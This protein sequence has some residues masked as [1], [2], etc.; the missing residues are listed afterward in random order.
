[1][2]T[3]KEKL[4]KR[5][6]RIPNKFYY[7][8]YHFIMTDIVGKKYKP[9]YK[10]IDDI[11]DCKGPC[12]LIWNHLSRVDH[13]Y[14]MSL[15]YP[16]PINIVAAY[17]E[18]YRSHL[19][20]VFK[21]MNILPKK[22]FAQDI[23][24]IRAM[25]SI[26][27]KG[28]VVCFAPEGMSSIYGTN[29]P[30]VPGTGRFIKHYGIPVYYMELRGQYLTSTKVCLDERPGRTEATL[31]LLF[32]PE[33]LEKMSA[34]EIEAKI[35]ETF[36]SDDYEW[37]KANHIKW[38]N[39]GNIC[40]RLDDICYKCPRCASEMEM[41]ASGDHIECKKCGNG[42]KMN[43][44]YEFLPYNTDCVIP[45]SPSKWV[46]WERGEMIK[47]IR[48][49]ANYSLCEKVKLGYLPQD[50]FVKDHKTSEI[51]GEGVFS[52]DHTGVH[53]K[54][55]KLGEAWGF[56]MGWNEIYTLVIMKATDVFGIYVGGDYYEFIPET[57]SVGRILLAVEEMHRLHDNTWRNFPWLDHLYKGTELEKKE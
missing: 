19:H 52:L 3:Y 22:V 40:E 6:Y 39:K 55:T 15:A 47:A 27:S 31:S 14:A 2:E 24:G 34:E 46:E 37:G 9:H 33:M 32:T 36:R 8:I 30:I 53:F 20:T 26:I 25:N 51:C 43:D 49:D 56:D 28:G 48:E 13:L 29:Q 54:G 7:W 4:V 10:I 38:K 35:N 18:F 57:H 12:F 45:V 50:S 41:D 42:A 11:N 23:N 44:Y 5:K 16:R 17:S 1:M 21:M